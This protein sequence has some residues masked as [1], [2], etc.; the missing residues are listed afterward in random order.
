MAE[1]QISHKWEQMPR[2]SY[3]SVRLD[4]DLVID[5]VEATG[6]SISDAEAQH[7]L[8]N[9]ETDQL[10]A[11]SLENFTA[12]WRARGR[13]EEQQLDAWRMRFYTFYT[14][15]LGVLRS[16]EDV[17][18][19][20]HRR[21][22]LIQEEQNRTEA[23]DPT[24]LAISSVDASVTNHHAILSA[25]DLAAPATSTGENKN[26]ATSEA[27]KKK[28]VSTSGKWN[29]CL[30]VGHMKE[31]Q[32]CLHLDIIGTADNFGRAT[33]FKV[34]G[35][36]VVYRPDAVA[37]ELI[38]EECEQRLKR[39]SRVHASKVKPMGMVMWF[40]MSLKSGV[41]D[42]QIEVLSEQIRACLNSI[43]GDYS[44]HF[45]SSCRVRQL[46]VGS[47]SPRKILRVELFA[48][49]DVLSEVEDQLPFDEALSSVIKS[50]TIRLECGVG[51]S[52]M[53]RL[54]SQYE[55]Y[56]RRC[57]G[58][59]EEELGEKAMNPFFFN[60]QVRE[61]RAAALQAAA[62]TSAMDITS[63][64]VHLGTRGLNT[65]GAWGE[66]RKRAKHAF[67][68]QAQHVGFGELT[69]F[70]ESLIRAIVKR[71]DHDKDGALSFR[72]MVTLQ[73]LLQQVM[74]SY[75]VSNLQVGDLTSRMALARLSARASD[76]GGLQ[77]RRQR[78]G[79]CNQ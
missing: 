70:G 45:F 25:P 65:G 72:E 77:S 52:D 34:Q 26:V 1:L 16:L 54:A 14:D 50:L 35:D 4:L 56:E 40:D 24:L 23:E 58:P 36:A 28:R 64:K 78:V 38:N 9:I 17:K 19:A 63:L 27:N 67:L 66:L 74:S 55:D 21:L 57:Y 44:G 49:R 18:M 43:P 60:R 48:E 2:T 12:W 30:N 73:R 10:G 13:R 37:L 79:V 51:L 42:T 53:I 7:A 61:R 75:R 15:C 8:E 29:L 39:V 41:I 33:T 46:Y 11:S 22:K 20:V 69:A 59:Q 32:S 31:A 76:A 62:G 3:G 6:A 68:L 47:R 5:L 71:S